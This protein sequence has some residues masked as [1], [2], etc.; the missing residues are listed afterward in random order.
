M[1]RKKKNSTKRGAKDISEWPC[2]VRGFSL[3]ELLVVIS[4]IGLLTALVLPSVGNMMR[5]NDITTAQLLLEQQ[6][7]KARQTAIARN[8][9][10]EIRFYK[11]LDPAAADGKAT[12]RAVQLFQIDENGKVTPLTRI[13]NLPATVL[14]NEGTANS[15][16]LSLSDITWNADNP[17]LPLPRSGTDYSAKAF[18]VRPDGSTSLDRDSKWFLTIHSAQAGAYA[19][20]PPA[21]FATV[22]IEPVIGAL[23]S[24]RP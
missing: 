15:S 20:T 21:N 13:V 12:F 23:Q 11:F 4:I 3:I 2:A 6:F 18:Q 7:V 17:K 8:C 5:A 24:Y 19:A 9:R 14:I 10:V 16:L 1:N 22:Q